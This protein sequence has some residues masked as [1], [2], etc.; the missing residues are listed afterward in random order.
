[1]VVGYLRIRDGENSSGLG[2]LITQGV[3]SGNIYFE[4]SGHKELQRMVGLLERNDI[5][6]VLHVWD[7]CRDLRELFA[8]LHRFREKGVGLRSLGEPWFRLDDGHLRDSK[9]YEVIERL[10]AFCCRSQR[11]DDSRLS[12][13]RPVGRPKGSKRELVL[14]LDAA[15]GLY[16]RENDLS[17]SEICRSVG[18]NER[19][20]YRHLEKE[21]GDALLIR[22]TK[23]RKRRGC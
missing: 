6:V 20:F 14:K 3:S 23:G 16:K 2:S 12:D 9:L 15:F 1:M 5:V 19:T 13:K 10:Y 8:L 4:S 21:G 17:V 7:L 11:A 22:R 18:L